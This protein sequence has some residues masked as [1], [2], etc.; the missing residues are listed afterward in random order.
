[1]VFVKPTRSL[2]YHAL[3]TSPVLGAGCWQGSDCTGPLEPSFSGPWE[4]NTYSPASRTLAPVSI[5][6]SSNNVV[7]SYP[8]DSNL[9]GD[10]ALLVFDFGQEV[11]GIVTLNYTASGDGTLGLAFTEAQN[12]TGSTSDSSNGGS[13][14]DGFQYQNISSTSAADGTYTLPLANLRGGFRYLTLFNIA[15]S[16]PLSVNITGIELEIAYQPTWS[17]L[18]AYGGYFH[19]SDSLLNRIWYACTYT[20]QTNTVPANTGRV[21][22]APSSGWFNNAVL[23]NSSSVVVDG[24]KRDRAIWSGD[25]GISIPSVLIGTGDLE[26]VQNTLTAVY[27]NQVRFFIYIN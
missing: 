20:V 16:S 17:N 7:S 25:L 8:G 22:P 1:M 3:L 27:S 21:W 6:D 4:A 9:I 18:Q 12:F 24:A 10:D 5:L 13:G 26:S 11:G 23:S 14:T 2:L 15:G 19:S